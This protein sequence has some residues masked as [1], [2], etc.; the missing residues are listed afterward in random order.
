[1]KQEILL[2]IILE[3]PPANVDF[4]LQKGSGNNYETIQKQR[5][6]SGDLVFDFTIGV[7]TAKDGSPDFSGPVVQG[8]AGN[9]FVYIGIGTYA[10]NMV[11]EWSRRLKVPLTGITR[12]V[13]DRVKANPGM[14]L[15]AHV[16]GTAKDGTP[17]CATVKPFNGWHPGH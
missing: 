2:K 6:G 17:A 1:M 5:S 3:N 13:I 12:G 4:G 11:S 16:A 14:S 7:K 9:R 8:P 10:G 15:Q